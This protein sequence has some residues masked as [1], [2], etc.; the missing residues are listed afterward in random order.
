[1]TKQ[2]FISALSTMKYVTQMAG[3]IV[4]KATNGNINF[5]TAN[6]RFVTDN[7]YYHLINFAVQDEG[8]STEQ[9]L[10]INADPPINQG[11]KIDENVFT[12]LLLQNDISLV[13]SDAS[14]ID[15]M[16]KTADTSAIEETTKITAI[17]KMYYKN[18]LPE[19]P[20]FEFPTTLKINAL[21]TAQIETPKVKYPTATFLKYGFRGT[22]ENPDPMILEFQFYDESTVDISTIG[23]KNLMITGPNEYKQICKDI[24]ST[25]IDGNNVFVEY[26]VAAPEKG[27]NMSANSDY[28]IHIQPDQIF[29]K[30]KPPISIP[31]TEIG[32]FS[33]KLAF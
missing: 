2:E 31:L 19:V 18:K 11:A 24:N 4:L 16:L 30:A 20:G 6:V 15:A 21:Q 9:V 32:F 26:I 17:Q 29:N 5:Y 10:Y 13:I 3:D 28:I 22:K 25:N 14:K 7:I 12:L 8:E 1:M 23:P 27:W 33:V